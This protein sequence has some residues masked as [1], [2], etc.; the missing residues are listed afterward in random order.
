MKLILSL[1]AFTLL[2][3]STPVDPRLIAISDRLLTYGEAHKI[4]SPEDAALIRDVGVIAVSS[5]NPTT[6]VSK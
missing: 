1:S 5:P 2:S 3:C 6:T 4:L